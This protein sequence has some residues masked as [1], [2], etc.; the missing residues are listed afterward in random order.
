L[1]LQVKS[2]KRKKDNR[3][4]I[5]RSKITFVYLCIN[6]DDMSKQMFNRPSSE[7]TEKYSTKKESK[8]ESYTNTFFGFVFFGWLILLLMT[9]G[10]KK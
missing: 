7:W 8:F 10:G 9:I 5:W 1:L 4:I 6:K 2:A 3:K